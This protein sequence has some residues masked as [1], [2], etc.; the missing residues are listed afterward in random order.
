MAE[1]FQRAF[2]ALSVFFLA[3]ALSLLHLSIEFLLMGAVNGQPGLGPMPDRVLLLTI[4]ACLI[5]IG[6]AANL[7]SDWPIFGALPSLFVAVLS[8]CVWHLGPETILGPSGFGKK[9]F[10]KVAVISSAGTEVFLCVL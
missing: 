2:T 1:P 4:P 3:V 9:P 8:I 5:F 6:W 10:P 7:A